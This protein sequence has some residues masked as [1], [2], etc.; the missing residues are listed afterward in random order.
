MEEKGKRS[1]WEGLDPPWSR[2][3]GIRVVQGAS[4]PMDPLL[5]DRLHGLTED[6]R[7]LGIED[8]GGF[9]SVEDGRKLRVQ[10]PENLQ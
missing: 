7:S 4:R 8:F 6:L 2:E 10:V 3:D 1:N 5:K 9:A